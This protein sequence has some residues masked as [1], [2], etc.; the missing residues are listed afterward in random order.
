MSDENIFPNGIFFK[1]PNEK[2]PDF[3]K[4]SIS[5]KVDEAVLWLRENADQGGWVNLDLKISKGGKPY[6]ALNTWKPSGD[7]APDR[8][9]PPPA[10][11]YEDDIPF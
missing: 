3:V 4:G 10:D 11:D 6:A 5:V 9:A 7:R 2:A 1:L 8:G